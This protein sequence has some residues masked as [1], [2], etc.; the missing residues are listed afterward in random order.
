MSTFF[1]SCKVFPQDSVQYS[2]GYNSADILGTCTMF[3]LMHT[4][5]IYNMQYKIQYKQYI[6]VIGTT[7][8]ESY[9]RPQKG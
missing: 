4:D 7:Y 8:T 9:Q 2:A 6:V 1:S 5:A 3:S